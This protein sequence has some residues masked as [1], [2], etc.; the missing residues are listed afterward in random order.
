MI[1][2]DDQ[3]LRLLRPRRPQQ[4]RP[5]RIAE[6]DLVAEP[7]N[8]IDLAQVPLQRGERD[9]V[10][11]QHTPDDL[12]KPPEPA[13]DHRRIRRLDRVVIRHRFRLQP[14][15]HEPLGQ[16]EQHRRRRHRDRRDQRRHRRA[17]GMPAHPAATAAPNSTKLNSLA[18]GKARLNRIAF[19]RLCREISASTK[20]TTDLRQQ[21][22]TGRPGQQR[23]MRVGQTQIRRHPDRDEEEP[24]Q[25]A[26][27]TESISASNSC[28]YSDS[29]SSTPAMNAP[30]DIESPASVGDVSGARHDQQRR[31]REDFR[32][33]A[34]PQALGS[35]AV[36]RTGRQPESPRPPQ[37][38]ARRR[39]TAH[40]PAAS[41]PPAAAPTPPAE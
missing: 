35:A 31:R 34:R 39:A 4:V 17:A 29:D 23:R 13:D 37:P 14:R 9:P 30:S 19:G 7:P 15:D 26:P 3:Q 36:S 12:A 20:H 11:P 38:P 10:H 28:R 32:A 21:Q 5:R 22:R 41:A 1:Q 6:I 24:Q 8:H 33:S 2:R 40:G 18:C 25:A 27:R 16:R